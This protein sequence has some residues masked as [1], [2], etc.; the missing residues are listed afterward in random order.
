MPE[1]NTEEI[2]KIRSEIDSIDNEIVLLL[3]KRIGCAVEIGKLKKEKKLA[4]RDTQREQQI[5]ERLLQENNGTFPEEALR[6]I[7]KLIIG[8]CRAVQEKK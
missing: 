5:Y 4:T 7:F 2:V 8:N 6:A 3:K 1:I